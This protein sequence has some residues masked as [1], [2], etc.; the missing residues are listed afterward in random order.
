ML[1]DL[2][3]GTGANGI[4]APGSS[5]GTFIEL[6]P[7]AEALPLRP[8]VAPGF[9][10]APVGRS[11]ARGK[12]FGRVHALGTWLAEDLTVAGPHHLLFARDAWL[13]DPTVVPNY[14][15]KLVASGAVNPR[16]GLDLPQRVVDEPA[17]VVVGWGQDVYGHAL[18]EAAPRV[19]LA[20][21]ALAQSAGELRFLL[22]ATAPPWLRD[23]LGLAGA[24]RFVEHD[25]TRERILL[26]Q[27]RVPSLV[28]AGGLHPAA[29][30]LFAG[31]R[32]PGAAG[33]AGNV[34]VTRRQAATTR[35]VDLSN[36][37]AIERLAER[38]GLRIVSPERL[39]IAEQARLFAGARLVVGEYGSALMNAVFC[40]PGAIVGAI[41]CRSQLLSAIGALGGLRQSFLDPDGDPEAAV[42]YRVDPDAFARWLDALLT[43]AADPPPE[44]AH[45]GD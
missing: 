31:M 5:P 9:T 37:E 38:A 13:A 39:P 6:A 30:A 2:P 43:A 1:H 10:S 16:V 36:A 35:R 4:A 12:T 15:A 7:P 27:A 3:P 42:G 32:P 19:A 8:L 25:P 22:P 33:V 34:Y 14:V 11:H 28:V 21:L 20:A 40:R 23:V 29:A 26:R 24:R 17:A 41:G 44:A 45:A 18:V